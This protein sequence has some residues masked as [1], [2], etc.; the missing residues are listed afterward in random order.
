MDQ[1][2][3]KLE[4]SIISTS[5]LILAKEYCWISQSSCIRDKANKNGRSSRMIQIIWNIYIMQK[6]KYQEYL[7]C[8][9]KSMHHEFHLCK[10]NFQNREE[11]HRNPR[12]MLQWMEV[13]SFLQWRLWWC[14]YKAAS[15]EKDRMTNFTQQKRFLYWTQIYFS[16]PLQI[17]F[18]HNGDQL[19]PT[20]NF[21]LSM[22]SYMFN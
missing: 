10:C 9:N 21:C 3:E 20:K 1:L 12:S 11:A 17:I 5:A 7:T 2:Q 4:D 19:L 8:Y 22:R 13:R 18:L 6:A 14:L 15:Q 16:Y